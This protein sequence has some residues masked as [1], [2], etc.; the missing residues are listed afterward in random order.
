MKADRA[1]QIAAVALAFAALGSTW[2][3]LRSAGE[4]GDRLDRRRRDLARIEAYARRWSAE[5]A[6]R[7]DLESQGRLVPADIKELAAKHL[8]ADAARVDEGA[9]VD[10]GDGW[11]AREVQMQM[12]EAD[13]ARV[14]DFLA[15]A[16]ESPP[17][18]RLLEAELRP[19][20]QAGKGSLTIRLE[21]VEKR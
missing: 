14:A 9:A 15:A 7:R 18:W 16:S 12:R 17:P 8:G 20:A 10:I 6:Y 13:Y 11:V 3:T 21:A 1:W 2:G 4:F 5:E 19:S